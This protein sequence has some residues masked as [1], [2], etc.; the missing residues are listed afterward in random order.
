MPQT[1]TQNNERALLKSV[2]QQP[3]TEVREEI[4]L[5]TA[6]L[7][8]GPRALVPVIRELTLRWGYVPEAALSEIATV[9]GVSYA[10]VHMVASF[11]ARLDRLDRGTA[12][13]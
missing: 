5:L 4:A 1:E 12:A 13:A 3:A 2:P 6:E 7:G 8:A 9:L 10:R 11:Y